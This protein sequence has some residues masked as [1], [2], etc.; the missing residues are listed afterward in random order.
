VEATT[1]AA[2][3]D[4]QLLAALTRQMADA[5]FAI[6]LDERIQLWTGGA[7]AIYGWSAA[8][9]VGRPVKEVLHATERTVSDDEVRAMLLVGRAVRFRTRSHRRDGTPIVT[10][11][12]AVPIRDDAG[13]ITRALFVTR[14][15][16]REAEMEEELSRS[17]DRLASALEGSGLGH[18]QL[19]VATG[20]IA[21]DR[22]WPELLGYAAGEIP[23]R[24]AAW[25]AL[26]DPV[27]VPRVRAAVFAH[28][29]G[30]TEGLDCEFRLRDKAGRWRWIHSRG[31]VTTRDAAGR[32]TLLTGTHAD[33]TRRREAEECMRAAL[34]ANVRLVAELRE[35]LAKVKTLSGLLPVCAWCKK[36]RDDAGYW[37]RIE[38]YLAEHSGATFT[39]AMCPECRAREFP[40]E[41]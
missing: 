25:V 32:A 14:D 34:E 38:T 33:V 40:D 13:R 2:A 26:A 29:K 37:Q 8:E 3:A 19:D 7:E 17:H 5:V 11:G 41:D 22:F 12:S 20:A 31:R 9:V 28:L 10:A 1:A 35:A 24:L 30:E 16:T 21:Y 39:H 15:V 18:W 6:G 36:I 23:A 4:P 27:D